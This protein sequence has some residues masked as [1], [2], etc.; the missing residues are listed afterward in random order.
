MIRQVDTSIADGCSFVDACDSH[1]HIFDSRFKQALAADDMSAVATTADDYRQVQ[2]SFGTTR[3]VIVTPR[4]YDVDNAVTLDAISQ[5][6]IE[7]AR[8][9]ATIRPDITDADLEALH[10]GGIRGIRFTLYT[11]DDAPTS[12]NM[13]ETLSHRV[14]ELGWHL[15]LHWTA[16][17]I[18]EYRDLLDRMPTE[19]V[20]D[21]LARLPVA[22]G[23]NH[24][25]RVLVERWLSTGRAWL[26]LSAPYLDS[27]VGETKAY[28]DIEAIA[29]H[30][31]EVAP[32]RLVWGSDWPHTSVRPGPPPAK[33]ISS[34]NRWTESAAI[35]HRIL[36]AN[37]AKLYGF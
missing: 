25:A 22:T 35:R 6:G 36:V 33:L 29:R 24:P 8:G 4:N 7:R 17:Q 15:Q 18:V 1:I 26:K 34:L 13:V 14:H 2:P 27:M 32:D 9:I 21:H 23:L 28:A 30:W 11:P 37:P 5:L 3:T 10:A 20:F 19:F 16:A 12:F 31:V